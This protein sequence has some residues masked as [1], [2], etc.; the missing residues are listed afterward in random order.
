MNLTNEDENVNIID[1]GDKDVKY[2]ENPTDIPIL[3]MDNCTTKLDEWLEMLAEMSF[4]IKDYCEENN[5]PIFNKYDTHDIVLD[6]F[7][8]N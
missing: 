3:N 5:L 1:N 4:S 7:L 2:N 8:N 6:F